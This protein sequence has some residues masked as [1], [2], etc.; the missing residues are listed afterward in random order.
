LFKTEDGIYRAVIFTHGKFIRN[1]LRQPKAKNN[2]V[3]YV[4]LDTESG[5]LLETK[6]CTDFPEPP[7]TSVEGCRIHK[8]VQFL[9]GTSLSRPLAE[10]EAPTRRTRNNNK[11]RKNSKNSK[12]RT[13]KRR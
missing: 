2:D 12:N 1:S 11:N 3:F 10:T 6:K 8:H 13:H 4:R 9:T 5:D 7:T